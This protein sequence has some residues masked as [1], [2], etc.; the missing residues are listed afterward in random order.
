MGRPRHSFI[1]KEDSQFKIDMAHDRI[2]GRCIDRIGSQKHHCILEYLPGTP[3]VHIGS[4]E[5]VEFLEDAKSQTF[6]HQ[7]LVEEFT[8]M[9]VVLVEEFLHGHTIL[10]G[11]LPHVLG[12]G[13]STTWFEG[14][15][16]FEV[17]LLAR[18]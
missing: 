12:Q 9:L 11:G 17:L 5:F 7:P 4:N 16:Q 14:F 18:T 1:G 15:E 13:V 6:G 10:V 8:Q 2:D 3:V